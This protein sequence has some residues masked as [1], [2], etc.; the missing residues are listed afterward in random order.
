M[1]K[2]ETLIE[3]RIDVLRSRICSLIYNNN[4]ILNPHLYFKHTYNK[5]ATLIEHISLSRSSQKSK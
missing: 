3:I 2:F 1:L 5:H 4:T